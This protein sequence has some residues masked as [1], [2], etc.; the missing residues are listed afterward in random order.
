MIQKQENDIVKPAD[1]V[2]VNDPAKLTDAEK[3]K[4]KQQLKL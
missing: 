2:V 1:K 3:E 4:I